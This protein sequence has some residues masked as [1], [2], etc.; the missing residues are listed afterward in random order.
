MEPAPRLSPSA[1]VSSSARAATPSTLTWVVSSKAWPSSGGRPSLPE[2]CCSAEARL[3]P[4]A[5]S[6]PWKPGASPAAMR[7]SS[8]RVAPLSGSPKVSFTGG[9]APGSSAPTAR[10]SVVPSPRTLAVPWS[11]KGPCSEPAEISAS[12]SSI[13]SSLAAAASRQ[14]TVPSTMRSESRLIEGAPP[15]PEALSVV[16]AGVISQLALPS[17]RVSSRMTGRVSTTDCT[18]MSPEISGKSATSTVTSS[19]ETMAGSLPPGA[20]W[21]AMP[22]ALSDGEGSSRT[23][24]SPVIVTSRPVACLAAAATSAL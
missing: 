17:A 24:M 7:P 5:V 1:R 19:S 2:S 15:L 10:S 8:V 6:V 12:R 16:A 4:L 3:L 11:V 13:R 20:F 23:S 21:K 9:T 22:L 14:I 18:W